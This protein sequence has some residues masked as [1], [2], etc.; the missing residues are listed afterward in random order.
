[1]DAYWLQ[2]SLAKF[3]SDPIAAQTKAKEVLDILKV[4]DTLR[5]REDQGRPGQSL[6]F[7]L[8]NLMF[9]LLALVA[10]VPGIVISSSSRSQCQSSIT[11]S[12]FSQGS[13][14]L[15]KADV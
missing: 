7:Q 11:T 12:R 3:Y 1:M 8:D 14:F 9:Q 5:D 10:K 15:G 6:S 13:Q 4:E 2:R